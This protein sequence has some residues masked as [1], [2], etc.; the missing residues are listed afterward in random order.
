MLL[1]SHGTFLH[2]QVWRFHC[3]TKVWVDNFSPIISIV[4]SSEGYLPSG[5]SSGTSVVNLRSGL[6]VFMM[7]FQILAICWVVVSPSSASL[8]SSIF[9]SSLIFIILLYIMPFL[10][11]FVVWLIN[12]IQVEQKVNQTTFIPN[13]AALV[14]LIIYY[15]SCHCHSHTGAN[16]P[17]TLLLI[18]LP[19]KIVA[20]I[21]QN[22][23]HSNLTHSWS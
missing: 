15:K 23:P 13:L 1:F 6:I 22:C 21:C 8:T 3:F 19:P 2:Y 12:N 5:K 10:R 7:G 16:G 20:E 18:C 17:P 4:K 9:P 14:P 11:A